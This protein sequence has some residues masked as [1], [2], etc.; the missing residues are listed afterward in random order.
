M[1]KQPK[2]L[3]LIQCP[4]PSNHHQMMP[5]ELLKALMI[6]GDW[7][8]NALTEA[9]SNATSKGISLDG[10]KR[11]M[12]NNTIPKGENREALNKAIFNYCKDSD[13]VDPQEWQNALY[14]SWIR[15]NS[16]VKNVAKTICDRITQD[17]RFTHLP[18][19]F[20]TDPPKAIESHYLPLNLEQRT[21]SSKP[22]K[23][24][25]PVSS[26]LDKNKK[27]S[28]LILADPGCGK[29]S[30]LRYIALEVANDHWK[31]VKI[32][33]MVS[34]REYIQ[35]QTKQPLIDL[36]GFACRDF[37]ICEQQQTAVTQSIRYS[38]LQEKIILLIDGL[39]EISSDKPAVISLYAEL[40]SLRGSISW[41]AVARPTGLM[42]TLSESQRLWI[43]PLEK[44][45]IESHLDKVIEEH[46]LS[47]HIKHQVFASPPLLQLASNPFFLT[48]FCY[49]QVKI[50]RNTLENTPIAIQE[51]IL[52]SIKAQARK[53]S[54]ANEV[55]SNDTLSKL[56]QFSLA[57][58]HQSQHH[59]SSFNEQQWWRH[60]V[61][62][63]Q[64]YSSQDFFQE[65]LP[66]RLITTSDL[67]MNNYRFINV[68]LQQLLA[69]HAMLQFH[70]Q[71]A[72]S[73]GLAIKWR[74]TFIVYAALCYH[75]KD[76]NRF[77]DI[78]SRLENQRE[79]N[80]YSEHLIADIFSLTGISTG[81]STTLIKA[82]NSLYL[83]NSNTNEHST[84]SL[85][86]LSK[87]DPDWFEQQLIAELSRFESPTIE[88]DLNDE[89]I[90]KLLY[91]SRSQNNLFK[92]FSLINSQLSYE[93]I[94]RAFWSSEPQSA[95]AASQVFAQIILPKDY[96]SILELSNKTAITNLEAVKLLCFIRNAHHDDFNLF[97]TSLAKR[98]I[99]TSLTLFKEAC[100]LLGKLQPDYATRAFEQIL[101]D[102]GD[103]FLTCHLTFKILVNVVKQLPS[104]CVAKIFNPDRR[105]FF[106]A[107]Y[108]QQIE[109]LKLINQG[110]DL[111]PAMLNIA[112]SYDLRLTVKVILQASK[113]NQLELG[114]II[115]QLNQRLNNQ[116]NKQT[117]PLIDDLAT[118]EQ[119]YIAKHRSTALS[120]TLFQ[121]AQYICRLLQQQIHQQQHSYYTKHLRSLLQVLTATP[122]PGVEA[123]VLNLLFHSQDDEVLSLAIHFSGKIFQ[124]NFNDMLITKLKSILYS[125]RQS[126]RQE[127]ALAMGRI[128]LEAL[129]YFQS[130]EQATPALA[131]LAQEQDKLIFTD[132]WSDRE[133]LQTQWE[134]SPKPIGYIFDDQQVPEISRI[135][136]HEMSRY[137]Y[138]ISNQLQN[139]QF[140]LVFSS[141]TSQTIKQIEEAELASAKRNLS[142]NIFHI[143]ANLPIS[144][145]KRTAKLLAQGLVSSTQTRSKTTFDTLSLP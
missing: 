66:A 43:A 55:L 14:Q 45:V 15:Y 129:N 140:Y 39:D 48:L 57:V 97:L 74:E 64:Q 131:A 54:H 145:A 138:C 139:C 96:R 60:C 70:P 44:Q 53:N 141:N 121:L 116:I 56:Q 47:T 13:T 128:N 2:K 93:V 106:Q 83:N 136:A 81:N 126:L 94:Y 105:A 26:L 68:S 111:L 122:L 103:S 18:P 79:I 143:P 32:P 25:Y 16:S 123:M 3:G 144:L 112:G 34:A 73:K 76:Y 100:S 21:N 101:K 113:R 51:F 61:K 63:Y 67:A 6:A 62:K 50:A 133:G 27:L 108:P 124:N 22:S 7:D 117:F 10:I 85:Q 59:H 24:Q 46:N 31:N 5:S 102:Q 82:R 118:I 80:L 8:G 125:N 84:F 130:A 71:D 90:E 58:T 75:Y 38:L 92:G 28:C 86:A 69:A 9:I 52:D 37:F 127:T 109:D 88:I 29:S 49:A 91:N 65:V 98:S 135:F 95:I 1:A 35:A 107:H 134:Y 36:I 19:L 87:L 110:Q 11:W 132:F 77:A 30:L 42:D 40:R 20:V 12:H 72:L 17:V 99:G 104:Q 89:Q 41:I 120:P 114:P 119:L 115:H 137:G 142:N 78:I 23:Q 4:P 33:L